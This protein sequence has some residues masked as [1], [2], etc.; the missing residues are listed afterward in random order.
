MVEYDE[1]LI[2]AAKMVLSN[3]D[4]LDG[5]VLGTFN[6]VGFNGTKGGFEITMIADD[7]DKNKLEELRKNKNKQKYLL[8]RLD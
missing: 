5:R 8:V 3:D 6:L 2:R 4:R 1:V 7:V